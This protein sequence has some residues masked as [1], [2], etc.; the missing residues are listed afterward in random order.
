MA[1]WHMSPCERQETSAAVLLRGGMN[2]KGSFVQLVSSTSFAYS[3]IDLNLLPSGGG[4]QCYLVD[5]AIGLAGAEQVIV[6]NVLLDSVRG[7]FQNQVLITLPVSIPVGSRLSARQQEAGGAGTRNVNF[8]LT[9]RS[10]GVN[11][12]QAAHGEAITYGANAAATTGVF[13]DSGDSANVFGAW[14]EIAAATARVHNF[15]TAVLGTNQVPTNGSA[16]LLIQI[17][18]GPSGAEV[19]IAEL[20]TGLSQQGTRVLNSSFDVAANIP[21]GSRLSVRCQSSSNAANVRVVS[22]ILIGV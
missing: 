3:A 20:R 8:S 1:D 17:G 4:G 2:S 18:I 21:T 5:V 15:L 22:A 6:S 10:G 14:I 19:P 7:A 16:E 12:R 11:S 9:G 13:V